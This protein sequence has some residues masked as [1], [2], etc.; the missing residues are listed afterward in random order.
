MSEKLVSELEST[1]AVHVDSRVFLK[2][3]KVGREESGVR[4]GSFS[5]LD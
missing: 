2:L 1:G 4:L 5:V 3:T